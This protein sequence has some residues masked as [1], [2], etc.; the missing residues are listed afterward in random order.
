MNFKN[1]KNILLIFI[2]ILLFTTGCQNL[3]KLGTSHT[4][5]NSSNE[6]NLVVHFLDVGQADSILIQ[7]PN[8]ATSLID[9]GNRGDSQFIVEYIKKLG[10]Q[11]IDYL[12]ATHPHEDH[13]GGLP[14]VIKNFDIGNVY[15]PKK[16]ASTKIF[17]SLVAEIKSN[18]IK[19]IEG[20]GGT[21]IINEAEIN[22]SI[23][24]PN[25]SEYDET[26]DYSIVTKLKYKDMSFIFTGDAEKISEDEMLNKRYDL[27]ANVLKVGHHGGRTSTSEEFLNKI[28]PQYAVI[29]V[30][31]G[32][33]YGHPHKE[34]IKRLEERGINILRTDEMGTIVL[35]SDGVT[36][37]FKGLS[38][39]Q[40]SAVDDSKQNIQQ[41]IG[42]KNTKVYHS[43][44]CNSLP[45]KENQIIF[46]SK[47]DA[48]NAGYEPHKVC[49]KE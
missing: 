28:E 5:S 34:T 26:N 38:S 37:N 35:V 21:D 12:L 33:D 45:K 39:I 9:G 47:I 1:L 36:L 4:L 3:D 22:F 18:G 13:I 48:E 20:K 27:S 17:E 46:N 32:N 25:S 40:N 8:G 41:Y 2:A 6:G 49:I 24:A 19:A 14:E 10:I 11:K 31:K 29:S 30:E 23:I 7:L 44:D 43:G 15:L 16:S 42:N